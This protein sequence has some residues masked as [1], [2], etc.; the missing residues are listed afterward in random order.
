MDLAGKVAIVTGGGTGIGRAI[1]VALAGSGAQV[2]VN[3]SRSEEDAAATVREVEGI[4]TRAIA[5]RADV[6]R[7]DDIA[8][9]VAR[10]VDELGRVDLLVNNAGMTV[11]VP[12][13]DL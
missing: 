7:A 4:G 6:S 11:F 1:S 10:T 9:M 12:F 2:A 8:Q 13:Q 3:Y 5:V